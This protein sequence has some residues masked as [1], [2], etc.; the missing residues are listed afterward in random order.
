MDLTKGEEGEVTCDM[1]TPDQAAYVQIHDGD[2][3]EA[4][5]YEGSDGLLDHP[6][7]VMLTVVITIVLAVTLLRVYRRRIGEQEEQGR[8]KNL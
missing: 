7:L 4:Y 3:Q 2:V 6:L 5:P 8:E 1:V